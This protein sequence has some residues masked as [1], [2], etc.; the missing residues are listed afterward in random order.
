MVPMS[1]TILIIAKLKHQLVASL[2]ILPQSEAALFDAIGEA[3]VRQGRRD[4][5][6]SRGFASIL[7]REQ[8]Q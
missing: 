6:E 3:I 5:V 8:W 7:F 2:S 4:D 1:L